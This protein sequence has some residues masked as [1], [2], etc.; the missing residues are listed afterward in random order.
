MIKKQKPSV[1]FVC[2]GNICRSPA[3]QGIAETY[4]AERGI[5]CFVDSAGTAAYH[6]GEPPHKTMQQ[7]ARERGVDLSN[8]L[9]RSVQK[10]DFYDFDWIVAMD[11]QN[12]IDLTRIKPADATAE[13]FL[14]LDYAPQLNLKDVPDPYYGGYS[15]FIRSFE[16]IEQGVK[17]FFAGLKG[18]G[19]L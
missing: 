8:L 15:G 7:A 2:L 9:A 17:G 16:I 4:L 18:L 6:T 12:F 5:E 11:Q 3:A 13:L 10:N 1:L 14:L 19:Q